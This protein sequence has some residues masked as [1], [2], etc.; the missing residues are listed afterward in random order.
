MRKACRPGLVAGAASLW[1]AAGLHAGEAG[2]RREAI[3]V[4]IVDCDTFPAGPDEGAPPLLLVGSLFTGGHCYRDYNADRVSLTPAGQLVRP[5]PCLPNKF[6]HLMGDYLR[7]NVRPRPSC[8]QEETCVFLTSPPLNNGMDGGIGVGGF[9]FTVDRLEVVEATE[10]L[11]GEMPGFVVH[12]SVWRDDSKHEWSPGS[13]RK[14][15]MVR[16]GDGMTGGWLK[17]GEYWV[18]MHLHEL[19]ASVAGEHACLYAEESH[20]IARTTFAVV[21]GD[22]WGV[23]VWDQEPSKAAIRMGGLKAVVMEAEGVWLQPPV[24]ALR[25]SAPAEG[26]ARGAEG[27]ETTFGIARPAM[28]PGAWKQHTAAA[29]PLWDAR[30]LDDAQPTVADGNTLV[31]RIV[32]RDQR[33]SGSDTA[34]VTRVEWRGEEVRIVVNLW[35]RMPRNWPDAEAAKQWIPELVVPLETRALAKAAGSVGGGE[36]TMES[37]ARRLRVKVIWE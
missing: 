11:E 34:E 5:D 25:T 15:Q 36:V 31:V 32:G 24:F 20:K 35:R 27:T 10:G 9:D 1:C 12:A 23:H 6:T 30:A 29:G 28:P 19:K 33:I 14:A 22:P 37:L 4:N 26:D 21:D 17:K 3:P 7:G 13:L 8:G 16:L 18:E 2:G